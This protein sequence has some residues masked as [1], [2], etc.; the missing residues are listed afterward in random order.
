[1]VLDFADS[2]IYIL[3]ASE[4]KKDKHCC[5][6]CLKI[7]QQ[8]T[9]EIN[10]R[11]LPEKNVE[12]ESAQI[13]E[14]LLIS[15]H[16]EKNKQEFVKTRSKLCNIMTSFRFHLILKFLYHRSPPF[17]IFRLRGFFINKKNLK[18]VASREASTG[19]RGQKLR[20]KFKQKGKS[21]NDGSYRS[22]YKISH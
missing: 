8:R 14:I 11:R 10:K 5:E 15:K 19:K 2:E 12:D 18:S 3:F 21:I 6:M 20:Y 22:Y 4:E 17:C 1:M 7:Q 16:N 13:F 9:T